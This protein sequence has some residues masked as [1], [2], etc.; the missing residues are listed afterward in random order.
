[1]KEEIKIM[2][3]PEELLALNLDPTP[4][5]LL[6]R[7]IVQLDRD[8]KVLLELKESVMKTKWVNNIT[9]FQWADGSWGD[10]HSLSGVRGTKLTT[11][12][13]LRR[14]LILGL[15]KHDLPIKKA[16][17]YMERYLLGELDLRDR[18]EKKHDWDLLTRLFVAT[19]ILRVDSSNPVAME[20][21]EDWA[22]VITHA[23]SGG[24]YD[25]E[26][27]TE[28]YYEIHKAPAEKFMWGFQNFYLVALLPGTLSPEIES[29]FLDYILN[30]ESSIYYIY[31]RCLKE[32]PDNFCSKRAS[33]FI[34]AYEL[35]NRYDCSGEK[36]QE[37]RNWL[38]ENISDDG[39][40]DM[41]QNAK[42][43]IHFPLSNSWRKAVNRKIDCTIRIQKLLV[44]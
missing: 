1:M 11:E 27:Y 43:N 23:F 7:D 37:F 19:W 14:L 6:L 20:I 8:D 9:K 38:N 10:F 5:Y 35:L 12:Q 42:D 34:H 36:L 25:P 29:A 18:T 26:A 24:E 17:N 31:D 4:K 40:W 22:A 33:R 15:E 30:S 39:F 28:A 16:Q 3:S 21:A 32:F 41:T 13:A 44:E 2:I